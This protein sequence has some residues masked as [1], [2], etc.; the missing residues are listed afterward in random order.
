MRGVLPLRA[1]HALHI[2]LDLQIGICFRILGFAGYGRALFFVLVVLLEL[3]FG[4]FDGVARPLRIWR[5]ARVT[6]LFFLVLFVLLH[7]LVH[8]WLCLVPFRGATR[9]CLEGAQ[10]NR[11]DRTRAR[12]RHPF[13]LV[14]DE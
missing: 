9:F 8:L 7:L 4:E 11:G 2:T 14:E 13:R 3:R 6:L 5:V 1:E 12:R 10:S